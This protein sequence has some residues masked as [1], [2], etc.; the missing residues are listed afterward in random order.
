MKKSIQ[1]QY[2][3]NVNETL[4]LAAKAGFQYVALGF[5]SSKC[6]HHSD[7]EQKMLEL[8]KILSDNKLQCIQT[9]LP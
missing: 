5:G 2:D 7:W 9:H 8:E 4:A 3:E 1:I 6:F